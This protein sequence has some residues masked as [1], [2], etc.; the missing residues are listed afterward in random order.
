MDRNG[1][2]AAFAVSDKITE[3]PEAEKTQESAAS[4]TIP[5]QT[6]AKKRF[7]RE[8]LAKRDSLTAEEHGDYSGRI[9]KNLTSLP[10]YQEADAV[11]T[12]VSFRS[13]VDTF[14]MIECA[15]TDGKTVFAPK[16]LG[17][18]M[19]FYRIFSVNDLAAGYHGILEPAGGT[20]FDEWAVDWM[21]RKADSRQEELTETAETGKRMRKENPAA[22]ETSDAGAAQ[23][24]ILVCLPGAAFD[25]ARHRIG[26]GGGFYDRYLSGLLQESAS[27]DAVAQSQADADTAGH[28][29]RKV[30]TAALAFGCQ[31]FESIPWEA[32][33]I[34]PEHIITETEMI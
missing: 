34:C 21:S 22:A 3:A 14:P 9:L 17:K 24:H 7:R 10:C 25:R 32:H 33:D 5:E 15:L 23:P 1:K 2:R 13:E 18:E 31:I 8:A 20:S 28:L 26:Y 12:Y 11:L 27:T 19:Q 6:A 29:Q 16:V 4:V 30:T